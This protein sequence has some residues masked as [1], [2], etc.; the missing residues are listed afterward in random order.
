MKPGNAAAAAPV[1]VKSSEFEVP[2]PGVGFTTVICAVPAA[3]MSA[4]VI[5][6]V[7]CVSL[8]SVVERA[9]PFQFTVEVDM[10]LAPFTVNVKAAPPAFALVGAIEERE[11][12]GFC[13]GLPPPPV[14]LVPP[15]DE[16]AAADM[17]AAAVIRIRKNRDFI[18]CLRPSG[19]GNPWTLFRCCS[20]R[21]LRPEY[22]I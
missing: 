13:G 1:I 9:L 6:A 5:A 18:S 12:T 21:A 11:G 8:T 22:Y 4:A 7:S 16:Q 10:K 17:I 19:R 3:A 20:K 14:G 2:P 15:P